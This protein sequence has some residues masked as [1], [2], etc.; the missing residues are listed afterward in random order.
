VLYDRIAAM[1]LEIN[2]KFPEIHAYY[3]NEPRFH[4]PSEWGLQKE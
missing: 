2:E 4:T 1:T 3:K